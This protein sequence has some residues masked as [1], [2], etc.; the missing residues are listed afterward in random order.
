MLRLSQ[1]ISVWLIGLCAVFACASMC[2]AG[3]DPSSEQTSTADSGPSKKE[4][5][6][7]KTPKKRGPKKRESQAADPK[8]ETPPTVPV[9]TEAVT[10]APQAPVTQ[11]S[12]PSSTPQT[13]SQPQ[14]ATATVL[15]NPPT[16]FHGVVQRLCHPV[17]GKYFFLKVRW[18]NGAS[19]DIVAYR[20]Y[21]NGRCE[22]VIPVTKKTCL[23]VLRHTRRVHKIYEL[24]TVDKNGN[25]STKTRLEVQY[26]KPHEPVCGC[27][28]A[29]YSSEF[30][31]LTP[32]Y[33]KTLSK[34]R[35]IAL[36]QDLRQKAL[37]QEQ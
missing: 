16:K 17:K 29:Q 36:I 34:P 31:Q 33:L 20:L 10:P 9:T 11:V 18:K 15:P 23:Q 21:V 37:P 28:I 27:Q 1:A 35:I 26:G 4:E 12:T 32:E 24:S 13:P 7:K 14:P 19:P 22:K 25:E 5:P 30:R 2:A 6:K 8:Q 3:S